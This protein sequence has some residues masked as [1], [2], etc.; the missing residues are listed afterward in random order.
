M[1][2]HTLVILEEN[3]CATSL[4]YR[5]CKP[6]KPFSPQVALVMKVFTATVTLTK[7]LFVFLLTIELDFIVESNIGRLMSREL[8]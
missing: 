6:N 1:I 3:C 8:C 2:I 5:I 7:T 4:R